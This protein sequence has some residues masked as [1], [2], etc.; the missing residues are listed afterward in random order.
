MC[1]I[2]LAKHHDTI[3]T[4]N[5]KRTKKP[6][7]KLTSYLIKEGTKKR[8]SIHAK[9]EMQ[10]KAMRFHYTTIRI[11]KSRTLTLS[12]ADK[13]QKKLSFLTGGNAKQHIHFGRKFGEFYEN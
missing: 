7:L 1:K 4:K 6:T 10:M 2:Y 3:Y 8:C 13:K 12:N 11:A 5:N 9:E